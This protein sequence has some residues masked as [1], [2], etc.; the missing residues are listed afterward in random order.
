M[1]QQVRVRF[2]P[3]PTGYLHVGGART[4]LFNWLY[5]RKTGG[6]FILRIEDTDV[7]RSTQES[8]D[9][10][11]KDLKWLGLTW[12]EGP[13]VGGNYGPYYQSERLEIYQKYARE[14]MDKGYAYPC[15]CTEEELEAKRQK[16]EEE[17]R[18]VHYDQT[19]LKLS[20]EE[21]QKRIAA[22]ESYVIR[23]KVPEKDYVLEDEV[24]GR[25][26]WKAGTLGD[27]I[28]LRSSGMP[29]YN[30]CVV[31]DDAAMEITHVVRAEEHLTNTHRQLILY[32]ALGKKP[33]IFSHASLILGPDKSKLS[34]RHG[35]TAV[36]QYAIDGFLPEALVNFLALLGWNE[37]NDR[38]IYS[39][40]ELIEH[41]ELNR[42][43]K[44]PGVFDHNKLVWMNGQHLRAMPVD[45]LMPMVAPVLKDAMPNDKRLE[46]PEILRKLIELIQ[47][48]MNL[49]NDAVEVAKS[50]LTAQEP[51][52]EEAAQLISTEKS[53]KLFEAL[54]Q[55]FEK[56]EWIKEG[57][58][59]A[60]KAAGKIAEAKGKD[61]FM[62]IRVK[63]TG[64]C[65][66]PDLVGIL[67]VL[68]RDEVISRLKSTSER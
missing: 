57:Y 67:D 21:V 59:A 27:F 66:G 42:I 52:N 43:S 6:K 28:I 64:T 62:P 44:S 22:G 9:G 30:F 14:L 10:L 18:S 60:I 63:I 33:P 20:K 3:S 37:G 45:E 15:F 26:E 41:F 13:E 23:V 56:C 48:K 25:V 58:N 39:V 31:V 11:L 61:L 12:D 50:F 32:E 49:I 54:A 34:K 17:H 24:R 46:N 1:S 51:E 47:V 16:A 40:K 68:G 35:A 55:E 7:E 2:A 4:A 65:H 8:T 29:V 36:G 53:L 19:C 5:A 38:E